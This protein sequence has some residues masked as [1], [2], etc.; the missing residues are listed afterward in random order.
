[1]ASETFWATSVAD[2]AAEHGTART[3]LGS[4]EA[5]GRLLQ[6]GPNTL[7]ARRRTDAPQL[8]PSP[9]QQPHHPD[10]HRGRRLSLFPATA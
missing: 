5:A 3:G 8:A 1:M 10:P 4:S 9:V 2:L 6:Y 7:H